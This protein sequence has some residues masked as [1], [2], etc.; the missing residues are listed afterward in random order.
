MFSIEGKYLGQ[1]NAN[2]S[3]ANTVMVAEKV[4]IDESTKAKTYVGASLVH[5]DFKTFRSILGTVYNE[6]SMKYTS[7]EAAGI[8]D[9]L[10]NRK[11][12]NSSQNTIMKVIIQTGIY[13]YNKNDAKLIR[14]EQKFSTL[15]GA[16]YVNGNGENDRVDGKK[17]EAVTKGVIQAMITPNNQMD[18]SGGATTWHGNDFS[19]KSLAAYQGYYKVGFKFADKTHDIWNMGDNIK[20][21]KWQAFCGKRKVEGSYNFMYI[22]T[23]ASGGTIFMKRNPETFFQG[24]PCKKEEKDPSFKNSKSTW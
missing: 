17:L 22:S 24:Y 1:I 18:Y 4:E 6:T 11:E 2:A 19:Q 5:N 21:C 7:D 20:E 13:G 23:G 12:G 3:I 10:E 8:Y 15:A 9:V 14:S 16:S